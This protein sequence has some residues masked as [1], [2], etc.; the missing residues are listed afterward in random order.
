MRL[1]I[2]LALLTVNLLFLADLIGFIPNASESALKLR[3][4]LSESLALQFSATAEKGEFQIIQ[5]TLRAVV[6]RNEDIRSAAIRTED[7][8]LIAL[9]GEH[10]VHWKTSAD[11]KS[12]PTH[13]RVPVYRKGEKWATVEIR[14]APLW[15]NDL[16][17]GFTNSF[18]GLLVYIG[19]SCFIC[20]FFIIKKTLRELDPSLVIP[21]R[22]QKAFDV[23]QEGVLILD[24]KEQIVLANKAFAGLFGKATAAMIGLK[25]SE[26][27]WLDCQ[28]PKQV[29]RLPWV[30][31]LLE[32]LEQKGASLSLMNS[33]GSKI[34]L[35]VNAVLVTDDAGK[36]RGCLVTFD[37]ITQL[38]EKNFELSDLVEKL[39]LS[40]EEIQA[41]STELEF[42]ANR[43][44]L[45]RC[46]NRRSLE[47]KF[48]ECFIRAKF[49]GTPLSC[50]MVDIDF[51][52]LVND[53]YGHASGDQVI[54]AVA[55]VLRRCT[56]ENDLV[57]RYGGEEFCVVLP[58]LDMKK[59]AQIAERVRKSIAKTPCGGVKITVSLGVSSLAQKA[60]KPDEL[61]NQADKA[62]YLAKKSGR[63]RVVRWGETDVLNGPFEDDDKTSAEPEHL[64]ADE[65]GAKA[66]SE[67]VNQR[68]QELEAL[69]EKQ[70]LEI[71]HFGM[72][73]SQTGLPTR[74]LF[75]DR[76]VHE[77]ARS[78]RQDSLVVVLSMTIDTIKRVDETLGHSAAKQLV[79]ACGKRLNDVLRKDVDTVAVIEDVER[80]VTVSQINQTEFGILLT[81]IKQ[82][83]HVT[84][85]VK[86][87]LD[88]FEKPFPVRG[89]DLYTSPYIGVSVFPY[90]GQTV[91]DL[92]RSAVSACSYAEK[93]KGNN[94]YRFASHDINEMA[95]RTL[96]IE[97]C[98]HEAI[99]N[100][101]LQLH[102][103]PLIKT[104]T[105]R[106][107][108]FEALL[109]WNSA[110]LGAVPPDEFIP[111]AE[112][113]G[114]I[115]RIGDWV[116]V[117][118][119]RQIRDWL[120]A[121]LEVG[122]VAVNLSG[123][124][125]RKPDLVSRILKILDEFDL[126]PCML[127]IELTE[128]SL[129]DSNDKPFAVLKQIK[130]LGI[131]VAMDDF[132][133]GYSSLA[134][135]KNIPLSSIKIDRS[136][137]AGIGKDDNADKLL[138]SIVSM[139]H[140]LGLEVV[141]EGVE[142]KH[143]ADYL[144]ML[145]CE[146]LQGYFFGRPVPSNEAV[147]FLDVRRAA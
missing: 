91:E 34:K 119:C 97:S 102:F 45:T 146:T 30:R 81:D 48:D 93:I 10:L 134:Y 6:D 32:G 37:D 111:V 47:R 12:T 8:Q 19:L 133:T 85:V 65:T 84:W 43:D 67:A 22:V 118:A 1:S 51:F 82:V 33:Q 13:V 132:G 53:R 69:L 114:A 72:Y 128:S 124:Q 136:F 14:F 11:G 144:T 31:I 57:G 66:N 141:A 120:N 101:E 121:G 39:Q 2:A 138:A 58:D 95:I 88:T 90:D 56:R 129:V 68:V 76:I 109:R 62:L 63:N 59:A 86:R 74:S 96:Q 52:K 130:E 25:G 4:G 143:Q 104:A 117:H 71:E 16:T 41:K 87:L 42:L 46:L 3:Q 54:R 139:A 15:M 142:E 35:A 17:S 40:H 123:L 110:R 21:E 20:Y 108:G 106:I 5:N 125:L 131:R 49:D 122:S 23:L 64:Q 112:S 115:D 127:E 98:L 26:L 83:D 73:D 113:S 116:L 94:R 27:G 99:D 79:E 36:N 92:Y 75:E 44:P 50:L 70:T 55:D 61:V 24:K 28:N 77:I 29:R 147:A 60:S 9:A 145:G 140:R 38:E 105:G 137:I 100:N 18:T 7:G 126:E 107:T 89:Q 103:Q 135:L 78:K 80:G